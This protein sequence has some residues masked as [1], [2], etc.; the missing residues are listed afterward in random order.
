MIIAL[1]GRRPDAADAPVSRF[2]LEK[3]ADVRER[4]LVTFKELQ[5]TDLVVSA[6]CGSDLLALA[7]AA[8]LGIR[9]HIVLPFSPDEFRAISV[10]DRPGA[11]DWSK[12]FDQFVQEAEALDRL[13]L[14]EADGTNVEALEEN[15]RLA[16][17]AIL[18]TAQQLA[19]S[20]SPQDEIRAVIVWEGQSRGNNDLTENFALLAGELAIPIIEIKTH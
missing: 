9:Y 7:A 20:N 13:I 5:A 16:N 12:F 1:A 10:V 11:E 15:F 18:D 6:S 8:D 17:R 3:S 14:L 2:P 4:L 19:G